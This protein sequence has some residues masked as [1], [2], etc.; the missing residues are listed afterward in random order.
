M[1]RLGELKYHASALRL[2]HSCRPLTPC[3]AQPILIGAR[4]SAAKVSCLHDVIVIGAGPA[5]NIAARELASAGYRVAVVDWRTSIG[6]KLCTGIVGV[7]CAT[8]FPVPDS[9]VYHKAKSAR[10]FSPAG[11]EYSVV[12]ADDQ[13]LIVDRE[14]YIKSIAQM[15]LDHGAAYHL[16]P[17]V[18]NIDIDTNG[19]AVHTRMG[20]SASTL[21]AELVII[22]SGFGSPLLEM[23]GLRRGNRNDFMLGTQM[24]VEVRSPGETEVYIRDRFAP[25]AFGWLVPLDSSRALI[26]LMSRQGL[27]GHLESFHESLTAGGRVGRPI[28]PPRRWG[29]PLKPIPRTYANRT[30]VAGDAAGFAKPTTGGGIFYA[31]LSGQIAAETAAAALDQGDLS[32]RRLKAYESKWKDVF[33]KELRIGYGAR[34]LFESMSESQRERLM[35]LF[36][37]EGVL[38]DLITSPGFSFDWHSRTILKTIMHSELRTL[39]GTFGPLV[40]PFL[41][42]LLRSTL[43]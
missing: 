20:E 31:L 40:A 16:G 8:R 35:E 29:I 42:R 18:T 38:R 4:G 15:A 30:L 27:N 23:A 25:E 11:K 28:S 9:H 41:A 43:S 34:L 10:I 7:E 12:A 17:K 22:S 37:S 36:L 3:P 39:I 19:V 33:G 24:E 13:A 5:G 6:D 14:A 2:T 21:R 32:A 1:R 26:G